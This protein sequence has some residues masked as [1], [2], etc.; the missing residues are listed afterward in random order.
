MT[1]QISPQSQT[2]LR[3][4]RRMRPELTQAEFDKLVPAFLRF[5]RD[6]L[7]AKRRGVAS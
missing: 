2:W 6:M 5:Q 4:C 1:A 3:L 7:A